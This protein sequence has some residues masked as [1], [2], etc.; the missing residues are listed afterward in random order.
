MLV[1]ETTTTHAQLSLYETYVR[2]GVELGNLAHFSGDE[3]ELFK[4]YLLKK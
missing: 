2:D 4:V 3:T 1:S